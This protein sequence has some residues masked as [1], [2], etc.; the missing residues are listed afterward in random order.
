MFYYANKA[1]TA[2]V[3]NN[4]GKAIFDRVIGD[5]ILDLDMAAEHIPPDD[6][7]GTNKA[8]AAINAAV[9]FLDELRR[10]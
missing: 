9:D 5:L 8:I 4:V 7:G 1:A 2:S 3:W 10:Q 6:R